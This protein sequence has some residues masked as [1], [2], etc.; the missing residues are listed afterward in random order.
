MRIYPNPSSGETIGI[1]MNGGFDSYTLINSLG[2]VVVSGSGSIQSGS[3]LQWP[4]TAGNGIYHLVLT[5]EGRSISQ[6]LIRQA[7]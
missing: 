1:F 5:K 7:N 3:E 2:Q 4:S 6:T